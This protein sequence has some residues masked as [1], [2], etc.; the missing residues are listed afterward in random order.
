MAPDESSR[1]QEVAAATD[2]PL[3]L[4]NAGEVPDWGW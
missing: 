1:S 4:G 2:R 3:V